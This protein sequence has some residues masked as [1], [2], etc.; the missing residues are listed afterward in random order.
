MTST[1]FRSRQPLPRVRPEGLQAGEVGWRLEL[2]AGGGGQGGHR[3]GGE[4]E[5]Y[6]GSQGLQEGLHVMQVR[7]YWDQVREC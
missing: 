5:L 3:A 7:Q 2:G 6:L 1:S 4:E